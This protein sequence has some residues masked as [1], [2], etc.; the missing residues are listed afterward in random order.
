M[1]DAQ[2]QWQARIFEAYRPRNRLNRSLVL[3]APWFDA[4][5]LLVFFLLVTSRFVLQPGLRLRLPEAPFNAGASPYGL[6]AVVVVQEDAGKTEEEIL[7]FDDERFELAVPGEREKLKAALGRAAH[8]KPGQPLVIEADRLVRHG[9]MVSLINQAA[10]AGIAEVYVATRPPG[11][12]G[13][14]P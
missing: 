10:A 14:G 7:F 13:E 6:M 12:G 8:E 11:P 5:L 1:S 9:T 2:F 4:V 3:A